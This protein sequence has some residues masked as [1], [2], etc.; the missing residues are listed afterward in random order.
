LFN[1]K[2]QHYEGMI[3]I[4]ISRL[5]TIPS[6]HVKFCTKSTSAL[7]N[8]AAASSETV[9]PIYQT[10]LGHVPEDCDLNI[11]SRVYHKSQLEYIQ[12]VKTVTNGTNISQVQTW[13]ISVHLYY[14]INNIKQEKKLVL[15]SNN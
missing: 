3:Y 9:V 13:N 12:Y 2:Q 10:T 14:V 1:Q 7:I 6:R 5:G 15:A 11:H 4:F 8:E